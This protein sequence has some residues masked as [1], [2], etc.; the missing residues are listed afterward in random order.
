MN[1]LQRLTQSE[2]SAIMDLVRANGLDESKIACHMTRQQASGQGRHPD[3]GGFLGG[4]VFNIS[5]N[6]ML[7]EYCGNL[8]PSKCCPAKVQELKERMNQLNA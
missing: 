4:R 3:T 1:G 7:C 6:L 2:E 8:E 5:Y